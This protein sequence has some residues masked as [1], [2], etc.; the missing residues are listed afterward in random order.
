[1]VGNFKGLRK[2]PE[3]SIVKAAAQPR[4]LLQALHIIY[5]NSADKNPD[6]MGQTG[7]ANLSPALCGLLQPAAVPDTRL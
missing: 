7:Q 3:A 6:H 1:M 2:E 5:M 4:A